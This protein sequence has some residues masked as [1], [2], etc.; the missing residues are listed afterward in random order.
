MVSLF[1]DA[2][3]LDNVG[4]TV[5]Q[6]VSLTQS[7]FDMMASFYKAKLSA[8][9]VAVRRQ[10]LKA[11][12]QR[13]SAQADGSAENLRAL[14]EYYDIHLRDQCYTALL[15]LIQQI[16]AYEYA[17]LTD[18]PD[19]NLMSSLREQ[20]LDPQIYVDALGDAHRALTQT[21]DA[22]LAQVTNCGGKCWSNVDFLL[23]EL[24]G[25]S[26]ATDGTLDVS[27][28]IPASAGYS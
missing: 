9:N 28:E 1:Q 24:P 20:R 2:S 8:Q 27:I 10:M 13:A 12:A 7:K 18:Y 26:F 23:S 17:A 25:N 21:W 3:S 19:K 6:L 11:Q 5:A 14:E 4:E 22:E 15:F 16:Q